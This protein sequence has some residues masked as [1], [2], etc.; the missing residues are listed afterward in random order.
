MVEFE[1]FQLN[2]IKITEM[3]LQRDFTGPSIIRLIFWHRQGSTDRRSKEP[4]LKIRSDRSVII[5]SLSKPKLFS[6]H[7]FSNVDE[8]LHI[9]IPVNIS[10]ISKIKFRFFFMA[11]QT[12]QLRAPSGGLSK[13]ESVRKNNKLKVNHWHLKKFEN[14]SIRT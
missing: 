8:T 9:Y 7:F 14:W 10:I 12:C 11:Q 13:R 1:M 5:P 4:S 6:F 3:H 2:C